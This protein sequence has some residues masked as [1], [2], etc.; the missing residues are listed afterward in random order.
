MHSRW[1]VAL[2][3]WGSGG[4]TAASGQQQYDQQQLSPLF[5]NDELG[6]GHEHLSLSFP[7]YSEGTL[8]LI[9]D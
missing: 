4:T 2:H 9:V 5:P 8:A 7:D 1:A 3:Q 6:D